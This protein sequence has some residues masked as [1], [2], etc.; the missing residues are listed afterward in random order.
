MLTSTDE[1]V[2]ALV[3]Q[4]VSAGYGGAAVIEDVSLSVRSGQVSCIV[5]PNGAGKSTLLRAVTRDAQLISG[6]ITLDG[7][8]I[9]R[10]AGNDLVRRGLAWVPQ[11]DDVF[12]I[13]TVKEN[14]EL[15]GYSLA[16]RDSRRRVEE[17]LA[18][19]PLLSKLFSRTA[20]QLS[21]GERKLLA[22][23]RALMPGPSAVLLDEP[24]AGLS[25]EMTTL[26]LNTHVDELRRSGV[27]VL[28]VEQRALEAIAVSSEVHVMVDGRL[29]VTRPAH[30]LADGDELA[31]LF[32]GESAE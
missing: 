7:E 26:V 16:K 12:P 27:A 8:D 28:L 15:G 1:S 32:L 2:A 13:L 17:V 18:I 21:G 14:L 23:G 9:S 20:G 11:L 6:Q 5:G 24:T 25:P 22:I 30:L 10:T 19:F 31:R 3:L 4:K 29:K